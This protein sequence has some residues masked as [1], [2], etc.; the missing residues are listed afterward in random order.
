[1]KSV[2]KKWFTWFPRKSLRCCDSFAH[3]QLERIVV[4]FFL[5]CNDFICGYFYVAIATHLRWHSE[6]DLLKEKNCVSW[7]Y[8]KTS[9]DVSLY[10]CGTEQNVMNKLWEI[11][12]SNSSEYSTFSSFCRSN[13]A[14]G[15]RLSE[16]NEFFYA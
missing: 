2:F 7:V 5:P 11:D 9:V 12:R 13:H 3:W 6:S 1:M 10:C 14:S 4:V 15:R 16:N 8:G